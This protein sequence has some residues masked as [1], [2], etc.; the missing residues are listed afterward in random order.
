MSVAV[1]VLSGL[2]RRIKVS[3]PSEELART[4]EK[5]LREYKKT[6]KL[7]GFRAG[8]VPESM[9]EKR[10]GK[11]IRQEVRDEMLRK[12]FAEAIEKNELTIVGMPDIEPAEWQPGQ[13]FQ[14]EAECEVYP[15]INLDNLNTLKA[16][17]YQVE[18]SDPDIDNMLGSLADQNTDW[19]PVTRPAKEGDKVVI[20]FSGTINGESFEGGHANDFEVQIGA[21]HMIPGFEEGL[22]GIEAGVARELR[23]VFPDDYHAKE[24][25]G[26]SVEF[27]VTAKKIEEPMRPA[28]NDEFAKKIGFT[29]GLSAL[30]DLIQQR[31]QKE[32]HAALLNHQKES[33]LDQLVVVN[34]VELPKRLV[35]VEVKYLQQ[36]AKQQAMAKGEVKIEDAE[37]TTF[38]AEDYLDQAKH[39]VLLGLVLSAIVKKFNIRVDQGA[40]RQRVEQIAMGYPR[41][42]ELV[43]WLYQDRSRLAE[44]ETA[45][46]E[47]QAIERILE[48]VD[49]EPETIS[50]Q[51]AVKKIQDA[52]EEEQSKEQD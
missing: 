13:D 20:D 5:K 45:V 51:A 3:I 50:Y 47:D 48:A 25:A 44:I 24:V 9:I 11:S 38:P 12:S 8:K 1:E 39:R 19:S 17:K 15:T 27:A 14:F 22:V 37:T 52:R 26:Q 41:P 23:L 10:Y 36:A 28:V 46:L 30:R 43:Q 18:I 7:K 33:I 21:K 29:G 31:L 35:D 34:Q 6:I 42:Q 40:V 2:Q 4:Y 16:T 49:G 32:A